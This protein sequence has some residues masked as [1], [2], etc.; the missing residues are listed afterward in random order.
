MD[1]DTQRGAEAYSLARKGML[2]KL[3][4]GYR[5]IRCEFIREAGE[6]VRLILE[7]ALTEGS[8][9]IFPANDT[10]QILSVKSQRSHFMPA[11]AKDFTSNYNEEMLE[12]WVWDDW[13]ALS[14]ALK[15][16]IQDCFATGGDPMKELE[17]T[18]IQGLA[19]ALREYVSHGV[20]LG[21]TGEDSSSTGYNMMSASLAMEAK[22]GRTLSAASRAALQKVA[23]GID[24]HVRDIRSVQA[25]ARAN[26]LAGY[27]VYGS[28]S[29]RPALSTKAGSMLSEEDHNALDKSLRGISGHT[30]SLKSMADVAAR[31][32]TLRGWPVTRSTS[33]AEP[34]L[35]EKEDLDAQLAALAG[36]LQVQNLLTESAEDRSRNAILDSQIRI[37]LLSKKLA[38]SSKRR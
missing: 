31:T 14:S 16:S 27:Q 32:N 21:Y 38:A 36:S 17:N 35:E 12:D 19:S 8:I 7:A 10:S 24:G 13:S 28:A 34:T 30:K 18:V 25:I 2:S 6:S 20:S 37:N 11:T 5:T 1:L 15:Q 22:A 3:S 29:A 23:S 26:A 33:S 4:M 9:V